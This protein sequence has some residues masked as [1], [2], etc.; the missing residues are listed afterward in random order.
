MAG[1]TGVLGRRA[2][3]AL[4]AAGHDVTVVARSDG[5]A[6]QVTAAGASP[7]QLD[8]FDAAAV[9]AAVDGHDVVVNLATAIPSGAQAARASAWRTNDRLRREAARH[10]ADAVPTGGR[11]VGESITFPYADRGDD[12]IDE[13]AERTYFKL[14]RSV[15]DAEAGAASVTDRG[16]VGVTLRLAMFWSPDSTHHEMLVGAARKGWW[17]LPGR[18]DAYTSFVHVDDAARAVVAALDA[19][20]GIYNVAEPDP[21]P[22]GEHADALARAVGRDRLRTPPGLLQRMGGAAIESMARSQRISSR[23]LTDATGWKPGIAIVECWSNG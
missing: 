17:L 14:N 19:P 2:V 11:Y 9:Q 1:G 6:A 12:W 7:V 22:R 3:P 21:R 15:A 23:K 5:K 13:S 4:V 8:V 16:G 20:A 18:P 10:L